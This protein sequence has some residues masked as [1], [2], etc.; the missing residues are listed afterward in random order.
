VPWRREGLWRLV[1]SEIAA[2]SLNSYKNAL[3]DRSYGAEIRV[4]KSAPNGLSGWIGYAWGVSRWSEGKGDWFPGNY[5]QRHGLGLFLHYRWTSEFELSLKL[6]SATGI[7]LPAYAEKTDQGLYFLASR[8]N[9]ERLP[10]HGR[11]DFRLGKSF[12]RDRYRMTLFV[13]I[14]NLFD[15]ENLRFSGHDHDSVNP[16]TGRI[17]GLTQKQ[18]PFLP[19]AG[20][21]VEF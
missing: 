19:T 2:P 13:E 6:K 4:G 7:P 12:N 1:R 8:R 10:T 11:F 9:E 20:L 3:D 16:W 14:L 15:R 21:I 18:F 17:Y 5:D